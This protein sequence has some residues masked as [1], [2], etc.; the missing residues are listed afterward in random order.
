MRVL[1]SC[2][3]SWNVAGSYQSAPDELDDFE[4][5]AVTQLRLGPPIAGNNLAVEF[6]RHAICFHAQVLD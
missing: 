2:Q 1:F 3:P 4:L 5:V 6:D